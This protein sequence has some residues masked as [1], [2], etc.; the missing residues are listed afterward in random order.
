MAN[1]QSHDTVRQN[2]DFHQ[3]IR[4]VAERT[5][6]SLEEIYQ[7][8]ENK[9]KT[10]RMELDKEK[11]H[12]DERK[13]Q[14]QE[15]RS[16]KNDNIILN[17]GGKRILARKS[18]LRKHS[19]FVDL[20]NSQGF[21]SDPNPNKELF[22]DRDPNYFNY[23][24]QHIHGHKYDVEPRYM[25]RQVEISDEFNYFGI[26]PPFEA[27]FKVPSTGNAP[28]KHGIDWSKTKTRWKFEHN[29][30][31]GFN[32]WI[33]RLKFQG[34]YLLTCGFPMSD[35]HGIVL[36][37]LNRT[38]EKESRINEKESR[39]NLLK[40]HSVVSADILG[41]YIVGVTTSDIYFFDKNRYEIS[42]QPF[43][44][45]SQPLWK[46]E[47]ANSHSTAVL[48]HDSKIY[49]CSAGDTRV[50]DMST[51]KNETSLKDCKAASCIDARPDLLALGTYSSAV[52]LWD[53][54]Q[55]N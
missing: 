24:Y 26:T 12:F 4:E 55:N 50:W 13:K 47:N 11:R 10:E 37:N 30:K 48:L 16:S 42:S 19:K 18:S 35:H 44:G 27:A 20:L 51:F 3:Q 6:K 2:H 40:N 36:Y 25:S 14:G 22:I 32:G 38:N 29:F 45:E 46:E 49:T 5:T 21:N 41:N 9:F 1:R 17:V 31:V 43:S 8:M 28:V 33:G 53:K 39:I 15:D 52:L 23:V 54:R 34:N 7:N